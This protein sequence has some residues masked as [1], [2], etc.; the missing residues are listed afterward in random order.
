M[1]KFTAL[2]VFRRVVEL[3]GFVRAADDMNLSK[4]AVSKNVR[5]LETALGTALL[6]RTTRSLSLTDAGARYFQ[7]CCRILDSLEEADLEASATG[8]GMRGRLRIT[9]P[10][11]LGLESLTQRL[12]RFQDR[13]PGLA[14]DLVLSDQSL[15]LVDGGYDL[16]LR[17][18]GGLRDSS[19]KA[20]R[21]SQLDRVLCAA[22]SYLETTPAI[23]HP[24][25]LKAQDCLIFSYAARPAIWQFERGGA[26]ED[27]DVAGRLA[28]NNSI[29]LRTA[30]LAGRGVV[31]I[32]RFLV[33]SELAEGRLTALLPDWSAASQAVYAVYPDHRESSPKVRA[34]IDFLVQDFAERPL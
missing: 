13:F 31:L 32:P 17:G 6:T 1:D 27:V 15:D 33:R 34:L 23:T 25:D 26:R 20:R 24:Q 11:S 8:S 7:Q 22:P 21:L 9:A 19:L 10:M 29:A 30:V 5:E 3:N 14:L 28:I 2:R 16:A 4:A 18:S 12:I